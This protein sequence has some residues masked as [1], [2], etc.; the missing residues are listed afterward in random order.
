M[1]AERLAQAGQE[2]LDGGPGAPEDDGLAAGPQER[3]GPAVGQGQG[4]AARAGGAVEER[5]IDQQDVALARGAPLRSMSCGVRPVRVAGQLERIADRG[6]AAHDDR[7]RA[8][9][10]AQPQEPAEHVGDVAAED[11]AIACGARRRR[12]PGA[13]RRAG[14]TSCGGAGS[15]RGACPGWSPR[16]GRR[17]GSPSGSGPACRRR[18]WPPRRPGRAA[19]PASLNSATWS[20]PSALV[21]NR[22]SARADR[23]T[24]RAWRTG[25]RVAQ[26]LARR[27]RASTT[28]TSRPA[29]TASIASA[30]WVYSS[31]IPRRSRPAL[32]RGSSHSGSGAVRAARAGNQLVMDDAPGHGRLGQQVVQDRVNGG[33]CIGPQGMPPNRTDVRNLRGV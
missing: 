18:R 31:A 25:Q 2:Q 14:T 3:Q 23:S 8:V 29:W 19:G 6:R 16:S 10:G 22:N 17:C 4:R 12:S 20:W 5:G 13:A 33:R 7:L 21:G 28:T 32:I 1:L 11:A 24:A 27:G 15:P 26:G 9:V 30:W